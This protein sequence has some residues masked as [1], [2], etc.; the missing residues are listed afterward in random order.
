[1]LLFVVDPR[2]VKFGQN[3]VSISRYLAGFVVAV[4]FFAIILGVVDVVDVLVVDPR[5]IPLIFSQNCV[6]RSRFCCCFCCG[7]C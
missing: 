5:N 6:S 3:W 4:I 2:P 7:C 1:M